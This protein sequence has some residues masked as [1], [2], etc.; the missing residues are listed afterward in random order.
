MEYKFIELL[1]LDFLQST[2]EFTRRDMTF[3]YNALKSKLALLQVRLLSSP[4]LVCWDR[5]HR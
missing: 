1:S 4:K 3:R 2:E 5:L